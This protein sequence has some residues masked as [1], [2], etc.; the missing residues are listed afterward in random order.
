MKKHINKKLFRIFKSNKK[1]YWIWTESKLMK[2]KRKVFTNGE[3]VFSG[4]FW[5]D[6]TFFFEANSLIY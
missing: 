3:W 4:K 5:F 1:Y 6:F 2:T